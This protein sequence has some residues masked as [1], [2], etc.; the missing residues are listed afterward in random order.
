MYK[1]LKLFFLFLFIMVINSSCSSSYS[2]DDSDLQTMP[3][4]NNPNLIPNYNGAGNPMPNN[5][6][7]GPY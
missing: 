4:T 2:E 7:Q 3:V 5:P 6:N 1:L